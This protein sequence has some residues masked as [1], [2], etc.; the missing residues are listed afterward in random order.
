MLAKVYVKMKESVLDPQ[1]KAV[2]GSLHSLGYKEARDARVGRY[3]EVRLEGVA[4][5]DAERRLREMCE[6]LLANPIIEDYRFEIE[7]D[8]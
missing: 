5:E 2:L 1:G 4:R 8:K 7:E 6:K 3:I